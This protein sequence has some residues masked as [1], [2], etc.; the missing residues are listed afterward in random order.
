MIDLYSITN[1]DN[2]QLTFKYKKVNI[3]YNDHC[4]FN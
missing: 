1:S 3:N 2:L 4:K